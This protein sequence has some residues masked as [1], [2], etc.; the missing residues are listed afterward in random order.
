[1]QQQSYGLTVLPIS[2]LRSGG[3]AGPCC[4][5]VLAEGGGHVLLPPHHVHLL[6]GQ[7][8]HGHAGGQLSANIFLVL[9]RLKFI[10]LRGEKD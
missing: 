7:G 1:M 8:H 3:A 6:V 4:W 5:P 10:F 9:L 2:H